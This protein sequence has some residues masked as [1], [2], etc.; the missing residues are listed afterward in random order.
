LSAFARDFGEHQTV[1]DQRRSAPRKPAG[2][3]PFFDLKD[4]TLPATQRTAA[5]RYAE[6]TLF[7]A[8]ST[9]TDLIRRHHSPAAMRPHRLYRHGLLLCLGESACC[10]VRP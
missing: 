5:G 6:P 7:A 8:P 3:S 10:P 9:A 4:D 1:A 2:S